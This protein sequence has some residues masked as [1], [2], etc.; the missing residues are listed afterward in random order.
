MW[1]IG[2]GWRACYPVRG[3]K[4]SVVDLGCGSG[5]L[6]HQL[7][8]AGASHVV[9]VDIIPP[10]AAFASSPKLQ[11]QCLDLDSSNWGPQLQASLPRKGADVVLAFDILEHLQSPWQF[12]TQCEMLLSRGGQLVLTT[13]NTQS[14]E[15]WCRPKNWSGAHDPQHKHL[16]S[17]Y[18]LEF[19]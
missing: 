14:W 17:R 9:A 3:R 4:K 1:T 12:L 16:F 15:R 10:P 2:A 6:A 8:E 18:S 19:L 13:A 11:F 7:V 5:F